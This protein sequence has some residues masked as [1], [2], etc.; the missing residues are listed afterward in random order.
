[1]QLLFVC[2]PIIVVPGRGFPQQLYRP[3]KSRKE[4]NLQ[5]PTERRRASQYS[6]QATEQ[7]GR[8]GKLRFAGKEEASEICE[9][10]CAEQGNEGQETGD[11]AGDRQ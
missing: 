5:E 8:K 7:A 11:C 3:F 2:R 6:V 1:L 9:L 4:G 10:V